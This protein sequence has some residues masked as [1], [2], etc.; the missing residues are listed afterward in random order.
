M[1]DWFQRLTGFAEADYATTRERLEVNDGVLRSK[2]NG[3]SYGIG[4]FE[5]ASLGELRERVAAGRGAA[6]TPRVRLEQGDVRAMHA[7]PEFEGA[8]F[9]VASQTNCLEMIDQ[10]VRPEDGVTR[11]AND[12]TQGPACA[13]AAGAA[14]I[15]RNYFVPV[16]DQV[17]QTAQCQ[18]DGL[19]EV[20]AELGSR[21]GKPIDLQT[22][23][24]YCLPS[25]ETLD[26][27]NG[28]LSSA[29]PEQ[30]DALAA[31]LRVGVHADVEVTDGPASPGPLVT[32]I[33]CSAL[34][35]GYA[36]HHPE[37]WEAFA[38]M[39]LNA[40]YEATLLQAVLN[41][42]RGAS[43]IV[44]LT[45]LGGGA[46]ANPISWVH[47]AIR[48]AVQKVGHYDLDIRLISRKEP[49]AEMHE[50]VRALA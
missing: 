11:Y 30:V 17:G 19:R 14:T 50:L 24:G 34:P 44:L 21:L 28:H 6:G 43:N 35:L 29:A 2:V 5:L 20:G 10:D 49:S 40:A 4:R 7:L 39:V 26:A 16:G 41:A 46:F 37:C 9:Q 15:F 22:R 45:S 23:N 18:L 3:R 38:R 42:Q 48:H 27:I 47:D 13:I 25:R 32:Q 36:R 1:M 8:V 31:R 33:F 12:G